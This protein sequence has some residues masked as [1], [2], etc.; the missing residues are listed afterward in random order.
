MDLDGVPM[1]NGFIRLGTPLPCRYCHLPAYMA[2]ADEEKRLHPLHPCCRFW[3]GEQGASSCL[4]CASFNARRSG[5]RT[6]GRTPALRSSGSRSEPRQVLDLD[7]DEALL[8]ALAY[9][10]K[11]GGW[12]D[13]PELLP[14]VGGRL[15]LL[16]SLTLAGVENRGRLFRIRK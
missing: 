10:R 9:L 14:L 8:A 15:A 4:A 7:E 6:D 11:A 16:A 3:I 13:A 1:V 5:G 12:V 2:E